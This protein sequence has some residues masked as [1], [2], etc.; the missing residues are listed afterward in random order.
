MM[1]QYL[2]LERVAVLRKRLSLHLLFQITTVRFRNNDLYSCV[3]CF[4]KNIGFWWSFNPDVISSFAD[5][6]CS[7]KLLVFLCVGLCTTRS[8]ERMKTARLYATARRHAT[9]YQHSIWNDTLDLGVQLDVGHGRRLSPLFKTGV[10]ICHVP[11]LFFL[12]FVFG[13]V[14]KTKVTFVTFCVKR[15]SC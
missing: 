2:K 7:G 9:S 1:L 10:Y 14:A 11:P 15:F 6:V 3:M 13:E 5:S 8:S 12:G 4:L